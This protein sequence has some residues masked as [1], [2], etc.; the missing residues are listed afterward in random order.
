M[1]IVRTGTIAAMPEERINSDFGLIDA[2][3]VE[4]RSINGLSGSPVFV[5]TGFKSLVDGKQY[6]QWGR[7]GFYLLGLMQGHWD[8]P[9]PDVDDVLED[10]PPQRT[11]EKKGKFVNTGIAI[12][13]PA[14]KILEIIQQ[15]MMREQED[16]Q[17]KKLRAQ[18]LPV[19]DSIEPEVSTDEGITRKQFFDALRKIGRPVQDAPDQENSETSG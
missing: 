3:L 15:P 11:S 7:V 8:A 9:I 10:A 2:Y 19:M 5:S 18:R 4:A 14:T 16:E 13:V 17:V 6:V 1:P 12:V